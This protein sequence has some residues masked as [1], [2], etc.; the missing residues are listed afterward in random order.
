MVSVIVVRDCVEL[1]H[2]TGG[3]E[4]SVGSIGK[5]RG[6]FFEKTRVS[7]VVSL[8]PLLEGIWG[9]GLVIKNTVEESN[10]LWY[11]RG[12]YFLH[13]LRSEVLDQVVLIGDTVGNEKSPRNVLVGTLVSNWP[14]VPRKESSVFYGRMFPQ[15][16]IVKELRLVIVYLL[17][18]VWLLSRVLVGQVS[19]E[20]LEIQNRSLQKKI[21][22]KLP[23]DWTFSVVLGDVFVI[24]LS[25][26]ENPVVKNLGRL[27]TEETLE[28]RQPLSKLLFT[29]GLI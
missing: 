19:S 18:L 4:R 29:E 10:R 26:M 8:S 21:V 28:R 25:R 22:G 27:L 3:M 5:K 20:D 17:P 12:V 13:V 7:V 1:N 9:S 14:L 16:R 2:V 15:K 23:R 6:S 24:W 11:K